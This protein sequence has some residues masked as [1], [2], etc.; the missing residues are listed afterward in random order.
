M[1]LVHVSGTAYVDYFSN[2]S[3]TVSYPGDPVIDAKLNT[4]GA[5]VPTHAG[6]TWVAT[7]GVPTYDTPSGTLEVGDFVQNPDGSY[8]VDV[9]TSTYTDATSSVT[10]PSHI[11][12]SQTNP[13]GN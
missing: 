2:G 11:I 6:L 5:P 9:A 8:T 13:A 7:K 12:S 1:T 10:I 3:G 4:P